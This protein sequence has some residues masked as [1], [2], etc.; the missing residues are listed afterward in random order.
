MPRF[1]FDLREV[2]NA[3]LP[4]IN[5][6]DVGAAPI[7][8]LASCYQPL[9]DLG[10]CRVT[11]FEPDAAACARLNATARPGDRFLPCAVGDGRPAEFRSC[12]NALTSSLLEPNIPLM[13]LFQNLA[14]LSWVV[15][16]TPLPTRRLDD[17]PE[18]AETDFIKLDVQG[19]ELSVLAHGPK[20]LARAVVVQ[21]EVEF[22]PLYVGQPLFAEV[23]QC[24]RAAGFVFHRFLGFA[25]RSFKPFLIDANVNKPISQTLWSDAVY[26]RDF[27]RLDSL[28]AESLLKQAIILHAVYGSVDLAYLCL[29]AHDRKTGRD[30]ATRYQTK[31]GQS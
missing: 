26:V 16:R 20:T 30:Y 5:V 15:S 3:P 12:H 28:S 4:A 31:F 9:V 23:D 29:A 27:T 10:A 2:I 21:T 24:L 19:A 18:L 11:G 1:F 14:E 7:D 25:G 22:V 17:I 6:V 8:G 13:G